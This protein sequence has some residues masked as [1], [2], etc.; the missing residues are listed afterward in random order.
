M[1]ETGEKEGDDYLLWANKHL[2]LSNN[3][4]S[5][6]IYLQERKTELQAY[7]GS[8]GARGPGVGVGLD[9]LRMLLQ[10]ADT[11]ERRLAAILDY[12]GVQCRTSLYCTCC[13]VLHCTELNTTYVV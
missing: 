6:H 1:F 2:F 12:I 11:V 3:L 10:L 7:T 8:A 9:S 5:L 4:V 13:T